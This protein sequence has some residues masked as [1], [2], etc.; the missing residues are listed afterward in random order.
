MQNTKQIMDLVASLVKAVEASM[1]DGKIGVEDLA[2]LMMVLPKI[3]PAVD[4][5]NEVQAE[6]AAMTEESEAELRTYIEGLYGSGKYELLA[7][8]AKLA[9]VHLARVLAHVRGLAA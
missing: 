3:G 7:E 6:I 2:H 8:D 5:V 4:G 1:A 9:A